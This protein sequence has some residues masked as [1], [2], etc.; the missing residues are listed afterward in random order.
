[1]GQTQVQMDPCLT[2][3]FLHPDCREPHPFDVVVERDPRVGQPPFR[4]PE[5][6][7]QT[8]NP[9]PQPREG[10]FQI[11]DQAE[12]K[13]LDR[14]P[15]L[16][17]KRHDQLG[18]GRRGCGAKVRRE[19]GD[20][21]IRLVAHRRDHRNPRTGNRPGHPLVVEGGEILQRT[22]SP[23]E[24]DH[25]HA[26]GDLHFVESADDLPGRLRALDPNRGD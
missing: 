25:V 24:D 1:M 16:P 12:P 19:I 11:P 9:L 8:R 2:A 13:R 7:L 20:C 15:K 17:A 4:V 6:V 14:V 10:G 3:A 21:E 26:P 22:A 5:T 23:R 18:R